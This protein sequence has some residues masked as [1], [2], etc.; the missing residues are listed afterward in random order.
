SLEQRIDNITSHLS[1]WESTSEQ[2]VLKRELRSL[3][4]QLLRGEISETS[5]RERLQIL[6]DEAGL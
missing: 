1:S 5:Y 4:D 6:L 3:R 2:D